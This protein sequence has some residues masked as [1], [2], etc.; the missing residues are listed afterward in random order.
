MEWILLGLF[1]NLFDH[2][3]N[4]TDNKRFPDFSNQEVDKSYDKYMI[5]RYVSM[6]DMFI[7][8]VLP[9]N[10]FGDKIPDQIHYRYYFNSLPQKKIFFNYIKKSNGEYDKDELGLLYKYFQCGSNDL[11]EILKQTPKEQ[12]DQI[13]DSF[14]EKV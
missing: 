11:V 14:K 12:I 4:L 1:L 7:P 9:M 5:N 10:I 13:I 6:I 8:D 2:L 3:A